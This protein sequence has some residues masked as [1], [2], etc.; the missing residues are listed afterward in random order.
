MMREVGYFIKF[1]G[2]KK[3]MLVLFGVIFRDFWW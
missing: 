2:V 1:W 3:V